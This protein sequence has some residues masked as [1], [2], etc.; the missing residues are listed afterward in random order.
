M[1]LN[2]FAKQLTLGEGKKESISVAQVKEVLKIANKILGGELYKLVR[3]SY[4]NES[5]E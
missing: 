3:R 4:G 1:N 2:E 5:K